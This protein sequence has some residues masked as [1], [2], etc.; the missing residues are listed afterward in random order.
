MAPIHH[1]LSPSFYRYKDR[2]ETEM[3]R[4]RDKRRRDVER[5]EQ[6]EDAKRGEANSFSKAC[7][8]YS[9]AVKVLSCTAGSAA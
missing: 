2:K 4:W 3:E 8:A 1:F 9:S 5:E 6:T 7:C